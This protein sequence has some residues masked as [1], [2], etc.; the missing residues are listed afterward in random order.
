MFDSLPLTA[1]D[2]MAWTWADIEP[3]F[4]D[5][6]GR[7]LDESSIESWLSDWTR[8]QELIQ[9]RYARL[10]LA[11]TQDTTDETAEARFY[12]YLSD[13]RPKAEKATHQLNE[14]LL[15]SGLEPAGFEIP[16]RNIRADA[17]LFREENLPLAVTEQK[18][19][20]EYNKIVGAQTVEWQGEERTMPQ[21][22]PLLETPNRAVR[23]ELWERAAGRVMQDREALNGLWQQLIENR[24]QQGANVGVE[25]YRAMRWRMLRRFE[26][27]PADCETFHK[28]IAEAVV[29]A[30]TRIYESFRAEQGIDL[31]RPWDVRGDYVTFDF[32]GFSPFEDAEDLESR[33]ELI[34]HQVDPQLGGF[35]ATMRQEGLLDLPNRR[36]KGPGAFCTTFANAKRPFVFMNAVG[37][38]G[39][40]RTMLHECGHAFHVFQNSRLPFIHQRRT[41]SEFNEVASM[42]M[43][44]LAAPYIDESHGGFFSKAEAARYRK[45]HLQKII[46]FWPYMAVVDA[47][48]HWVYTHMDVAVDPMA[49]DEKWGELWDK[50]LPG[51]DFTG[52]EDWKRTGWHRKLH[53]FRLP[54][55]YVEYGLAQLG[56]LQVWRNSLDDQAKAVRQY[57]Q[58]LALGGTQPIP[59]LFAA[60]G[61]K[62]GFDT[63][64]VSDLVDLI[65][66]QIA[67]L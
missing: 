7:K 47:F 41:T 34:F 11:N 17:D 31:L 48:Q 65:E 14:K 35:Y 27:T 37:T 58:A 45:M 42:A 32:P 64:L 60:A 39:D 3:Y 40:V 43:E 38:G 62:F 55:Y 1:A 53:I 56:A 66:Q 10:S 57:K 33:S 36:G 2:F 28:A 4:A 21:L 15:N 25:N 29:P 67:E 23:Q 52:L 20:S 30:A 63:E 54:F 5:L 12:A 8:L 16:L 24:R 18:L 50:F 9:E 61:A 13:I 19:G 46:L 49:C 59:A 51:I 26:Y 44:L 22:A 6:R